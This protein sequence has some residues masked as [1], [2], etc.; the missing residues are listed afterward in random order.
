[1][2]LCFQ[3]YFDSFADGAATGLGSAGSMDR[4]C[5]IAVVAINDY[6]GSPTTA[7]WELAGEASA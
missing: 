4:K 1:M 7:R 6:A 5:L 3:G 2:L